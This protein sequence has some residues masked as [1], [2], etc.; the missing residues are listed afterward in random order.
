MRERGKRMRRDEITKYDVD[1]G[2]VIVEG[3]PVEKLQILEYVE[4]SHHMEEGHGAVTEEKKPVPDKNGDCPDG[5]DAVTNDQG[6]KVCEKLPKVDEGVGDPVLDELR[7]LDELTAA[8][9]ET[10]IKENKYDWTLKEKDNALF[11]SLVKKWCK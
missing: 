11:E 4:E 9:E 7:K 1:F 6:E 8:G 5:W 10:T 3:I 2:D